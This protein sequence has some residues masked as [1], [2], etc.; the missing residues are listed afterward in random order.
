M[1]TGRNEPCPCGSG[2]KWKRCCGAG[3]RSTHQAPP[4]PF[5]AA[6]AYWAARAKYPRTSKARLN[7]DLAAAV[8]MVVEFLSKSP[9]EFERF[10]EASLRYGEMLSDAG[11]TS[12]STAGALIFRAPFDLTPAPGDRPPAQVLLDRHGASLPSDAA[13]ALEALLHGEDAFATIE[14]REGAR[15]LRNLHDGRAL[16]CGLGPRTR[17]GLFLG[18]LVELSGHFFLFCA[19][20]IEGLPLAEA[21]GE[22]RSVL[23]SYPEL[24]KI[25]LS[26][27]SPAAA[28]HL[29]ASVGL[30]LDD[31]DEPEPEEES[32]RDTGRLEIVNADRHPV[33]LTTSRFD[34]LDLDSLAGEL[35]KRPWN[36][37]LEAEERR[38]GTLRSLFATLSRK[39][40]GRFPLSDVNIGTIRANR[41]TAT[42]ETNS[43]ERD[44]DLRRR[45]GRIRGA[46]RYRDTKIKP[47]EQAL[48]QRR[49]RK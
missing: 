7:G 12:E 27:R 8:S 16:P 19:Q 45:L 3:V 22:R 2:R 10:R 4:A 25:G 31:E 5:D 29:L 34:V 11:L 44:R 39:P 15:L 20:R 6:Q 33:V 47:I 42:L 49:R 23:S 40:R 30:A 46:L 18:R 26:H 9:G 41:R 17:K 43:V 48:G 1:K 28:F 21:D 13:R 36:A 35:A 38:D 32:G 14:R 37:D 24:E